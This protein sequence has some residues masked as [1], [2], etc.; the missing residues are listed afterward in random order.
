MGVHRRKE[1]LKSLRRSLIMKK[2]WAGRK[3]GVLP[4]RT[5]IRHQRRYNP[6]ASRT[7][8][9]VV[10]NQNTS[11]SKQT[12][13]PWDLPL[14]GPL[15]VQPQVPLNIDFLEKQ[16]KNVIRQSRHESESE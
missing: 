15:R 13:A 14:D 16:V 11:S 10:Q 3:A 5:K 9:R 6:Q 7:R 12:P 8:N 1:N 2:V 4:D